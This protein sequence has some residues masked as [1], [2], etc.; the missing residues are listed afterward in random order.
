MFEK[1]FSYD[2]V[3]PPAPEKSLF[4]WKIPSQPRLLSASSYCLQDG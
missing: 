4:D 2:E 1:F 3:T